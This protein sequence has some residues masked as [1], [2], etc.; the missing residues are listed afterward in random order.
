MHETNAE[1]GAVRPVCQRKRMHARLGNESIEAGKI[2]RRAILLQAQDAKA[3]ATANGDSAVV[4]SK[5]QGAAEK[6]VAEQH[7]LRHFPR[8]VPQEYGTTAT[9]SNR[10]AVRRKREP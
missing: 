10:L 9:R 2:D 5:G 4:R 3:I 6:I 8:Q 7:R 1:H